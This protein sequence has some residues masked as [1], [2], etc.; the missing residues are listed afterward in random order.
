MGKGKKNTKPV[1]LRSLT[2]KVKV[3]KH[4]FEVEKNNLQIKESLGDS[5]IGGYSGGIYTKP[6]N[7][8]TSSRAKHD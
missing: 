3:E 4:D 6:P 1:S 2:F 8:C 5:V 7:S